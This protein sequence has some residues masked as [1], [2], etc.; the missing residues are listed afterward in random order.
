MKKMVKVKVTI[1]FEPAE[2]GDDVKTDDDLKLYIN[3]AYD[4]GRLNP[5]KTI[6]DYEVMIPC[7]KNYWRKYPENKPAPYSW[8]VTQNG[9]PAYYTSDN[10]GIWRFFVDEAQ[11]S[12]VQDPK[13]WHPILSMDNAKNEDIQ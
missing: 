5:L 4:L 12:G 2:F 10:Q 8:V 1:D 13:F 9:Y 7:K 3:Q 6:M 11:L